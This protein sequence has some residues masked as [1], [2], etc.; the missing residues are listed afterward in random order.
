M[1]MS[2]SRLVRRAVAVPL[3]GLLM[4]SMSVSPGPCPGMTEGHGPETAPTAGHHDAHA[5][6]AP[7]PAAAPAEAHDHPNAGVDAAS[8]DTQRQHKD[9]PACATMSHCAASLPG[10][11][12]PSAAWNGFTPALTASAPAWQPHPASLQ[13]LTPPPRA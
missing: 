8:L 9:L 12:T 6:H 2:L 11:G 4:G 10:L 7:T 1:S 3:L 5:H 13:H